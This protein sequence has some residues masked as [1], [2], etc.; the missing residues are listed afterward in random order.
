M[1]FIILCFLEF[2]SRYWYEIFKGG[3][4]ILKEKS[5]LTCMS[6]FC[7]PPGHS[8]RTQWD[9]V[10]QQ[11]FCRVAALKVNG[12]HCFYRNQQFQLKMQWPI[13]TWSLCN[14]FWTPFPLEGTRAPSENSWFQVWRKCTGCTYCGARR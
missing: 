10:N 12:H 9:F 3:T 11:Q 14:G 2:I 8:K 1:L 5:K 4:N 7:C 6:R 13:G